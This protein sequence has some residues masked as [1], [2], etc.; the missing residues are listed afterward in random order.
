MRHGLNAGFAA[1]GLISALGL[2]GVSPAPA[3]GPA[4]LALV[5]DSKPAATIV[6]AREPTRITEFAVQELQTHIEL[7]TGA[8]LPVVNDETTVEGPRVLVGE[9]AATTKL[10]LFADSFHTQEYLIRFMPDTLVLMGKD[11]QTSD[12]ATDSPERVPGKFGE[13]L[14][15]DG[16][17]DVISVFDCGFSDEVGTMEAWV[18]MPAER[19]E[20]SHGTILRLDGSEPW[21]YHIIQRNMQSSRITYTTYDGTNGHGLSSGELAE[22]WHHVLATHDAKEGKMA[23]FVDRVN[24]GTTSYIKTTCKDAVLGIGGAASPNSGAVGNPFKGTI[25]EVRISSATRDIDSDASG[26]PCGPDRD[27]TLLFHFDETTGPPRDSARAVH[28][29][30]PPALF[31][32]NGTLHAVYDFLERFCDV[33]WYA[34]SEIG[35]VCPST[36]ILVVRGT[37]VRR[38]PAMIHRWITPTSLYMPGPA[39]RVPGSDVHLWKLRMRIGGQAFWVCHSFGGYHDRFMNEHPDWFAR[40]YSGRPPQMCYTNPGFVQQIIRDAQHYFDG[41]GAKRG[42]TARGDVFGLVPMDNSRWC[43]CPRCQAEMNEA[44]EKN[45]QFNNGKAS[46]YVFNFINEVAREVRKTH[47]DR[48]IGALAYSSYAYYPGKVKVE[49]NVVVQLCLHTRNWWCPSMEVN[50]R[51]VLNDWRSRDP[52]RP[53]YVWLYYNFPASNGKYGNFHCFPGFF[54]Q[55]VVRQMRMYHEART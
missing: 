54:A 32:N 9:S 6:V 41:K 13:A 14:S 52:Q 51:K 5:R 36:A 53:L 46:D 2:L 24:C 16:G 17:K 20:T 21:T 8:T 48:W 29:V 45:L 11:T 22:G 18:W 27:T 50:D 19:Q 30:P 25:D 37:E 26:G 28:S 49:P 12:A 47:P 10:G 7:I 35:T 23:L 33:R 39:D 34:P 43:K 38:S 44:E 1:V 4:S 42:A 3:A 31:G 55:A 15:F 40:G